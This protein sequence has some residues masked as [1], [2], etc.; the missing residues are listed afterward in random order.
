MNIGIDIDDTISDTFETL[1]AYSQKYTIEDLKRE[2]NINMN[3]DFTNNLYIED[4]NGWNE[5]EGQKFWD[6]YYGDIL[7]GVNIK[8]FASDV[9]RNFKKKGHNIYLIT[10]RWHMPNCDTTQITKDWLLEN[11]IQYDKLFM[12]ASDKLQLVKDN[13]IDIFIDDSLKNCKQISDNTNTKVYF[14]TSMANK[15]LEN[16]DIKR[17][18]SWPE[19]DDLIN[20]EEN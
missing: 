5:L 18:Y 16:K 4:A 8:K 12:N 9:I 14:M 17:V 1:L 19:I 7:K 13:N 20:K 11:N 3:G 15:N 10:A 2:S 6:K